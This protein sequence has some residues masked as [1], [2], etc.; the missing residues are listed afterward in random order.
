MTVRRSL[1]SLTAGAALI[2]AVGCNGPHYVS[3]CHTPTEDSRVACKLDPTARYDY[4]AG[5]WHPTSRPTAP[6]GREVMA[7]DP[8]R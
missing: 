1:A 5:W 6:T 7:F 8:D 3:R 2:V 4:D